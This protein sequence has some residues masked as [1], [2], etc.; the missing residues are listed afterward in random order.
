MFGKKREKSLSIFRMLA[1]GSEAH[2][3]QSQCVMDQES[4]RT[5]TSLSYGKYQDIFF[6]VAIT[7]QCIKPFTKWVVSWEPERYKKR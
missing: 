4:H 3:N 2:T 7:K 6:T 5:L 1:I